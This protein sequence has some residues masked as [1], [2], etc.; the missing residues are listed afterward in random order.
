MPLNV[1][2]D[3]SADTDGLIPDLCRSSG[4]SWR[5]VK[6]GFP[7]N[8][9]AKNML[10]LPRLLGRLSTAVFHTPDTYCLPRGPYRTIVALHDVIPLTHRQYLGGGLK[11]R[12]AWLWR[13]WLAAVVS[14]A[15]AVVTVSDW[16]PPPLRGPVR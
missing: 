9:V 3:E 12:H 6:V 16:A 10:L 13:R 11:A 1:L 14:R 5:W 2:L 15:D 4:V 8:S 7:A